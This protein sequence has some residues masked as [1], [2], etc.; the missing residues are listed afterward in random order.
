MADVIAANRLA[1]DHD[2]EVAVRAGGRTVAGTA[3][4]EGGLVIDLQLMKGIRVDPA[5]RTRFAQ[6]GLRLG[7]VDHATQAFGL[8]L[9][10]GINSETGLAGLALGGGIG[11]QMRKHG[12]TIDHLVSA[13]VVTASGEVLHASAERNPA[14]FWASRGG[15]GIYGIVTACE[16]NLVPIGPS[17]SG[18]VVLYPAER[19]P[20]VLRAYRDWATDAPDEVPTILLL[21][22]NAFPWARTESLGRPILGIGALYVGPAEAGERALVPLQ[23]LGPVLASSI[24]RR[25]FTQHQSML[26][27]RAPAGRLYYWKSHYLPSLTDAAID[28]IAANAWRFNS[29]VSFTLRGHLGGATRRRSD[30]ETAFTGRDAAFAI[31]INCAATEPDLYERDRPWVREWFDAL[32]PHSTGG[33]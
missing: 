1:R 32:A 19:A 22:R 25:L 16:F 15:G 21:R 27:A 20:D 14:L 3:L 31:T 26:D 8:A 29:P 17:V 11:W 10:S 18:G 6:P 12:L 2:R 30:E 13:D 28:V 5:R 33:V 23:R 9:A 7:E 24:L 4:N